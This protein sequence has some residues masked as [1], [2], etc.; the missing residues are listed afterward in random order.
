MLVVPR[1]ASRLEPVETSAPVLQRGCGAASARAHRSDLPLHSRSVRRGRVQAEQ[2]GCFRGRRFNPQHFGRCGFSRTS[3]ALGSRHSSSLQRWRGRGD[4]GCQQ[5]VHLH[6]HASAGRKSRLP[7]LQRY[8]LEP[9]GSPDRSQLCVPAAAS[10]PARRSWKGPCWHARA[11]SDSSPRLQLLPVSHVR[12]APGRGEPL[13][14]LVLRPLGWRRWVEGS[15]KNGLH[16]LICPPA[17]FLGPAQDLGPL[18]IVYLWLLRGLGWR[19]LVHCTLLFT[20]RHSASTA[21]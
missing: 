1:L 15:A 21:S 13:L 19:L 20:A 7:E 12:V 11:Q 16:G 9:A 10:N 3:K 8:S 2:Q 5:P 6:H 17:K 14:A 18:L 4:D